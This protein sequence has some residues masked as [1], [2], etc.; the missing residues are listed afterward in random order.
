MNPKLYFCRKCNQHKEDS[1]FWFDKRRGTIRTPC[2][3]CSNSQKRH[4]RALNYLQNKVTK[5]DIINHYGA[6]GLSDEAVE[7]IS[8]AIL[9]NRTIKSFNKP[10]IK[11]FD[12]FVVLFCPA[13][14]NFN[15]INLPCEIE[16][17]IQLMN[18]YQELHIKHEI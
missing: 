6:K 16:R 14:G 7:F 8:D 18:N 3:D 9:L 11:N 1:E 4:V 12:N 2:K 17:M 5:S 15:K 10:L 13:C